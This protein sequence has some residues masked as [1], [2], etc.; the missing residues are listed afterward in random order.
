MESMLELYAKTLGYSLEDAVRLIGEVYE[1]L[2]ISEVSLV[3]ALFTA[4]LCGLVTWYQFIQMKPDAFIRQFP[5]DMV[6]LAVFCNAWKLHQL[7][8]AYKIEEASHGVGLQILFLRS[9]Y[10]RESGL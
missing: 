4:F 6:N 2:K 10:W 3:V 5:L 7:N 8:I 9:A 1:G